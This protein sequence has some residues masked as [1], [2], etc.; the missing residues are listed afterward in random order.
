MPAKKKE[1]APLD[2]PELPAS[3][4]LDRNVP[5]NGGGRRPTP[6][7]LKPA[8][9]DQ[10][11]FVELPKDFHAIEQLMLPGNTSDELDVRS[12]LNTLQIVHIARA[13]FIARRYRVKAQNEFVDDL[14]RLMI[15]H[16]RKGRKEVVA[17][18]QSASMGDSER[19]TGVWANMQRNLRA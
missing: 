5:V 18:H 6:P 11:G 8:P 3:T 4:I 12:E 9:Q 15:S 1:P 14:L 16:K 19:A 2:L 17:A 10:E 13:R 7:P